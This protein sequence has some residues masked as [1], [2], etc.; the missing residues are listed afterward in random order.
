MLTQASDKYRG[1]GRPAG[2]RVRQHSM[3]RRGTKANPGFFMKRKLAH[4]MRVM[5]RKST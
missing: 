3:V 2:L 4:Q 5:S 1:V